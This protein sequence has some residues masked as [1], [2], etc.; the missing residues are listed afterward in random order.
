MRQTIYNISIFIYILG[1]LSIGVFAQNGNISPDRPFVLRPWCKLLSK[2]INY[3]SR[4]L[5]NSSRT[6]YQWNGLEVIV[7]GDQNQRHSVN[8]W[9]ETNLWRTNLWLYGVNL[10]TQNLDCSL[11]WCRPAHFELTDIIENTETGLPTYY[12]SDPNSRVQLKYNHLGY[13]TRW[14]IELGQRAA[15]YHSFGYDCGQWSCKLTGHIYY[16]G[17]GLVGGYWEKKSTRYHWHGNVATVFYEETERESQA[18]DWDTSEKKTGKGMA[19]VTASGQVKELYIQY[20]T[21]QSR[22]EKYSYDCE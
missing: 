11:G 12:F 10:R 19:K 21:G 8:P 7:N 18:Y 22:H 5:W 17:E 14:W 2:E 9:G 6:E 3:R 15:H 20:S 13:L 4:S 16:D 1:C